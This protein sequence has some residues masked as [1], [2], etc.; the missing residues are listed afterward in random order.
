MALIGV[1]SAFVDGIIIEEV[2]IYIYDYS[3]A[4]G[5]GV[6]LT[7]VGSIVGAVGALTGVEMTTHFFTGSLRRAVS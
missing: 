4:Y 1:V 5:F 2:P 6:F 7:L 3:G